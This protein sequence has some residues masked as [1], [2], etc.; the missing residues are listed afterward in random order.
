MDPMMNPMALAT[1]SPKRTLED[2][3]DQAN[4]SR[5]TR[6]ITAGLDDCTT[7]SFLRMSREVTNLDGACPKDERKGKKGLLRVMVEFSQRHF[8]KPC[9]L[10]S[11]QQTTDHNCSADVIFF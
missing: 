3:Q 1:R 11:V 5:R 6:R 2:D 9:H 8:S 4:I 10:Q 7:A